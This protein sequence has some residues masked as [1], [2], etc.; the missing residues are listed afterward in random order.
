MVLPR[1]PMP[2]SPQRALPI[3]ALAGAACLL[4]LAGP[5]GCVSDNER[6]T[7]G[8]EVELEALT[9]DRPGALQGP[10]DGSS[11]AEELPSP[12]PAFPEGKRSLLAIDRANWETTP[13][14]VPVD[15]T[16]HRPTYFDTLQLKH[17]TARQR[18]QFPT[19]LTALELDGGFTDAQLV[20][21]IDMPLV[22][23]GEAIAVP[24][25]LLLEPQSR[26]YWSPS[27]SYDRW[28]AGQE[29]A[30]ASHEAGPG[31]PAQSQPGTGPQTNS[32]APGSK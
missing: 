4:G 25:R 20:E 23:T 29:P 14:L 28:P 27:W 5:T 3:A 12:V 19:A 24:F 18:G 10:Q 21:S 6:L 2:S 32:A 16:G 17:A 13:F 26:T 7:I 11:G 9:P 15:G 22:M 31:L 8:H 1:N 30:S